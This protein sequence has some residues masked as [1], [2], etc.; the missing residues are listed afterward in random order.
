MTNEP[1]IDETEEEKDPEE[2]LA[3]GRA[4]ANG[5]GK[6]KDMAKAFDLFERSAAQGNAHAQRNLGLMYSQGLDIPIDLQKAFEWFKKAADNNDPVA[7][8]MLGSMYATGEGIPVDEVKAVEYLLKS[9]EMGHDAAQCSIGLLYASGEGLPQDTSKA[10]EYFEK[11]AEQ[12]NSNAQFQLGCMYL[13]GNGVEKNLP[14]AYEL[15]KKAAEQEWDDAQHQLGYMCAEGQGCDK[16]EAEAVIWYNKA[17]DQGHLGST[18]NLAYMY[19]MGLGVERDK[20]KAF[21]LYKKAAAEGFADSQLNLA[22]MYANGDH[23]AKDY[24]WAVIW[25]QKAADQGIEQAKALLGD[26]QNEIEASRPNNGTPVAKHSFDLETMG[27]SFSIIGTKRLVFTG[28]ESPLLEFSDTGGL[29]GKPAQRKVTF[30]EFC[31]RGEILITSVALESKPLSL[32][33]NVQFYNHEYVNFNTSLWR[34]FLDV[35]FDFW[36]K[37]FMP[38]IWFPAK[39][40]PAELQVFKEHIIRNQPT[41]PIIIDELLDVLYFAGG[42]IPVRFHTE[43]QRVYVHVLNSKPVE[44]SLSHMSLS[45]DGNI[46]HCHN[47]LLIA[48]N[49]LNGIKVVLPSAD[50]ASIY[51]TKS[52]L[53]SCLLRDVDSKKDATCLVGLI[54]Q[55]SIKGLLRGQ[56][57]VAT[58]CDARIDSNAL[59][60]MDQKTGES[61]IAFDLKDKELAISG[62]PEKFVISSDFS[63]I[64]RISSNSKDFLQAIYQSSAVQEAA[65]RSAYDGPFVAK[66]NKGLV[67]IEANTCATTISLNGSIP[68]EIEISAQAPSFTIAESN[69]TVFI[70]DLTVNSEIQCLEGIFSVYRGLAFQQYVSDHFDDA[71][72]QVVGLEGFYLTYLLFGKIAHAHLAITSS[73]GVDPTVPFALSTRFFDQQTLCS[74][75]A[76]YSGV[77]SRDYETLL[78]YFPGFVMA[79]DKRFLDEACLSNNIDVTRTENYYQSAIRTCSPI[80]SHFL[81]IDNTVSRYGVFKKS[82]SKSDDVGTYVTMGI[83][84]LAALANPFI[85][86]SGAQQVTNLVNRKS[87]MAAIAA[88][89]LDDVFQTCITEWD[90]IIHTLLPFVSSRFAHEIYPVR[91]ANANILLKSYREGDEELKSRLVRLVSKR[92]GR[93]SAFREFPSASSTDL[94]RDRCVNFLLDMQQHARGIE[95]RPF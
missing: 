52:G 31:S 24:N 75:I 35:L 6:S 18:H 74:Y 45:V 63:T 48:N 29:L 44:L 22:I 27:H 72:S 62:T 70:G 65:T 33:G 46:I 12:G 68:A 37:S 51:L 55:V 2:L 20:S 30:K 69:A 61:F 36:A 34:P 39:V 67:R 38:I 88:E 54:G 23:I 43:G 10:V 25:A 17:A 95:E 66:S 26:L 90:Y 76:E 56:Q 9:A 50:I 94:T 21:D 5:E 16:N 41:K 13:N 93:L 60:L 86:I 53:A 14:F 64:L 83:T 91:L 89:T 3:L 57:I 58:A 11:A 59:S 19:D 8:C 92:L 71:V 78:Y 32:V 1:Y 79:S 85:I 47:R 42:F 84:G 81:R 4:Y 80:L 28:T 49:P 40:S 7:S 77:L 82:N 15:I 73:L 87:T